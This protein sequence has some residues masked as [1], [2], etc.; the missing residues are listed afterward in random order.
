MVQVDCYVG[1]NRNFVVASTL[2]QV[3][4]KTTIEV[5]GLKF[6]HPGHTH[7]EC[8]SMYAA[9][10]TASKYAKI[11]ITN[12]WSSATN[13]HSGLYGENSLSEDIM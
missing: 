2:H 1:Q 9:I 10:Q 13:P 8:H 11:F 4:L 12:Y 5:I 3:T 7:M 6:L